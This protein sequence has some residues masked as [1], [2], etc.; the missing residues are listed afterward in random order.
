MSR[1]AR[2][3]RLPLDEMQALARDLHG[4]ATAAFTPLFSDLAFALPSPG[5][6]QSASYEMLHYWINPGEVPGTTDKL[7][8]IAAF[9]AWGDRKFIAMRAHDTLVSFYEHAAQR[10]LQRCGGWDAAVRAIGE[11]LVETLVIPT[12]ALHQSPPALTGTQIDIPFM[13]GLLIGTFIPR[14]A[15]AIAGDYKKIWKLGWRTWTITFP[16]TAELVVKTYIGPKEITKRQ[17]W[18]AFEVESWLAAHK[19]E[20]DLIRRYAAY[21]LGSFWDAGVMTQ[22]DFSAL[23]ADFWRMRNKVFGPL[24]GASGA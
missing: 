22:E 13:D 21:R 2:G 16:A 6:P 4:K 17:E 5:R 20:A 18:V 14:A 8:K 7:M 23:Q 24:P 11:R 10:L 9:S 19:H 15:D 1:F 12:L 3:S